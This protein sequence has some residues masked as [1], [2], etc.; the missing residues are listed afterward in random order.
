[1][2]CKLSLAAIATAL[3]LGAALAPQAANAATEVTVVNGTMEAN[4]DLQPGEWVTLDVAGATGTYKID[5]PLKGWTVTGPDAGV[6]LPTPSMFTQPYTGGDILYIGGTEA[7]QGGFTQDFG[8]MKSHATYKIT[9]DIGWRL[10]V[11]CSGY[12]IQA[13]FDDVVK[14]TFQSADCSQLTQGAFKT[15][16]FPFASSGGKKLKV[17][18][19]TVTPG[20]NDQIN[21]DNFRLSWKSTASAR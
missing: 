11:R 18:L 7:D 6:V 1:M 17:H 19:S 15:L 16:S 4:V 21:Y 5:D 12:V 10:D 20:G 13:L 8:L 2:Q 9:L 14:H 3:T